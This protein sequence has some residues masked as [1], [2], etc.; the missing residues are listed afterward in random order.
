[1]LA[2]GEFCSRGEEATHQ[3]AGGPPHVARQTFESWPD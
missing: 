3:V 1:M 2:A